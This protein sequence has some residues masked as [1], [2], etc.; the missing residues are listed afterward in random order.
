METKFFTL[1]RLARYSKRLP[2]KGVRLHTGRA[3]I[4]YQVDDNGIRVGVAFCSPVDQFNWEEGKR[5]ALE[6]LQN[7]PQSVTGI[8]IRKDTEEGWATELAFEAPHR[9]NWLV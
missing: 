2:K 9:P 5:K 6:R 3:V 7:S 4:A 8:K 1:D